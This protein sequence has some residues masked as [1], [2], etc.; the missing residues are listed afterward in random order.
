MI[1]KDSMITSRMSVYM[2]L[3]TRYGFRRRYMTVILRERDGSCC[4]NSERSDSWTME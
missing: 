3:E 1:T 2:C 4:M